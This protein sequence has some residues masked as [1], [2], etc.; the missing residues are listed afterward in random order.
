MNLVDIIILISVVV[1]VGLIIFFNI[2]NFKNGENKCA[3]CPY[4]DKCTRIE[5]NPCDSNN[6]KQDK[7]TDKKD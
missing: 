2:K 3:K 4:A 1:I 5:T 7:D 6:T